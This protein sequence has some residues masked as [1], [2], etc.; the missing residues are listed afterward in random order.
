MY[1]VE[2]QLNYDPPNYIW[3]DIKSFSPISPFK[4]N[5]IDNLAGTEFI[6]D[7]P[8]TS[9]N[10]NATRFELY[11]SPVSRNMGIRKIMWNKER[12]KYL[13]DQRITIATEKKEKITIEYLN[14][15]FETIILFNFKN[16]DDIN[17]YYKNDII[18]E[19]TCYIK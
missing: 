5:E 13:M 3:H 16:H 7:S 8:P 14:E 17:L 19:Y 4:E 15:I 10:E 9:T 2:T 12:I 18:Q 1:R 11:S 6:I